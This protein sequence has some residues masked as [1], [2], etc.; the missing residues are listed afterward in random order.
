LGDGQLV[1]GP[2]Q[3]ALI[4]HLVEYTQQVQIEM[5]KLMGQHFQ[6]FAVLS[7]LQYITGMNDT[8]SKDKFEMV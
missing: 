7:V 6:S 3:A 4:H 8:D 5:P 2:G 1:G